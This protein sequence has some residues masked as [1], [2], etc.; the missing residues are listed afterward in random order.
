MTRSHN[1]INVL[2]RS[3]LLA[4]LCAE[5]APL[6]NYTINGHEYNMS[7]YLCDGIYPLW[8]TFVTTISGPRVEK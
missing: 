8:A 4:R 2:Q 6:C 3:P 7:Y 5:Q 1:D